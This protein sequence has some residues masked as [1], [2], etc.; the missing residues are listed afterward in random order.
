MFISLMISSIIY[1]IKWQGMQNE[2]QQTNV[3]MQKHEIRIVLG[4]EKLCAG[5]STSC[6][7]RSL[8]SMVSHVFGSIS[9]A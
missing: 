5:N 1:C 3:I 6:S 8:L 7:G 9:S 2:E 4:H